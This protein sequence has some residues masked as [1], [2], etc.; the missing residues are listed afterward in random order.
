VDTRPRGAG[1][2]SL[3]R[4]HRHWGDAAGTR[5]RAAGQLQL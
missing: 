4:I 1:T 5:M 2:G 3:Y